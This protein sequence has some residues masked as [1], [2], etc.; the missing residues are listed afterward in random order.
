MFETASVRLAWLN[1]ILAIGTG[2]RNSECVEL[3][4]FEIL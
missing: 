2:H 1:K 3:D 4:I